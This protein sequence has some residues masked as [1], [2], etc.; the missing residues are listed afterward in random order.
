MAAARRCSRSSRSRWAPTSAADW[1][2]ADA[3]D[4]PKTTIILALWNVL[5]G[6][7]LGD[8]AMRLR[9]GEP[10]GIESIVLGCSLTAVLAGVGYSRDL[11]R[12]GQVALIILTAVAGALVAVAVWRLQGARG[13]P[14]SAVGVVIVA[15]LSLILPIVL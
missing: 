11:A 5:V 12:P 3:G 10:D 7:W 15:A 2:S 13:F 6:L 4:R 8:E 9:R 1:F 14:V